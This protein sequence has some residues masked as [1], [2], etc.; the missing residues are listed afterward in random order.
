M[1]IWLESFPQIYKITGAFSANNGAVGAS[2]VLHEF[3]Y[4]IARFQVGCIFD[5][6]LNNLVSVQNFK[7]LF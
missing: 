3:A 5:I 4:P 1:D 7:K 6:D 2:I